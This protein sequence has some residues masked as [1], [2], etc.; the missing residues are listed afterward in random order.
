[1]L[2]EDDLVIGLDED[3]RADSP[4]IDLTWPATYSMSSV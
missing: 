2:A 4:V 1:M 3:G